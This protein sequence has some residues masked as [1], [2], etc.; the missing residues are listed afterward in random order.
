MKNLL[1]SHWAAS[2]HQK[3][4]KIHFHAITDQMVEMLHQRQNLH[5]LKSKEVAHFEMS[6]TFSRAWRSQWSLFKRHKHPGRIWWKTWENLTEDQVEE[7]VRKENR[8]TCHC[9]SWKGFASRERVLR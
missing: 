4:W 7:T 5:G 8:K 1:R 3:T 2:T 9:R 6:A